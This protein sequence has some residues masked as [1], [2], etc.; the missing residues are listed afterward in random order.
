MARARPPGESRQTLAFWI[1]SPKRSQ[2]GAP[3]L[4]RRLTIALIAALG[5]GSGLGCSVARADDGTPDTPAWRAN[6]G[7]VTGLGLSLLVPPR[8]DVGFGLDFSVRYGIPLGPIILAPGATIGGYY[9][10][11]HFIG[12]LM[13]TARVTLPLG[14]LAPFG[15]AGIGPGLITNPDRGGAAW[16]AGGGLALHLKVITLGLEVNYLAITSTAFET[17]IIGPTIGFGGG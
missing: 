1:A 12:D 11:S 7:V 13:A 15:H 2:Y 4:T 10:Q 17:V 5:F 3:M 16:M 14:P 8:G 6:T 9:L